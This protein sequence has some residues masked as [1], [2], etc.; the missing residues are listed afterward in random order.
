MTESNDLKKI[1]FVSFY[2]ADEKLWRYE[3]FI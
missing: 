3:N 1:I 2:T